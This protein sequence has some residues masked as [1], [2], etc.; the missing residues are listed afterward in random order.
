MRSVNA[1]PCLTAIVPVGC[2]ATSG[3][4]QRGHEIRGPVLLTARIAVGTTAST[5]RIDSANRISYAKGIAVQTLGRQAVANQ[6]VFREEA[7]DRGGIPSGDDIVETGRGINEAALPARCWKKRASLAREISKRI[8]RCGSRDSSC[9]ITSPGHIAVRVAT[10]V[11]WNFGRG[12][13]LVELRAGSVG[14][15]P[16]G[17]GRGT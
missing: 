17:R 2:G 5:V 15:V 1:N 11:G 12:I 7:A 3:Q 6:R 13:E 16:R 9:C 10:Q 4:S 14:S 8:V